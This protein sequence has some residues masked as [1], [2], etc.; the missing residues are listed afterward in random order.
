[1][2][3][4]LKSAT[5]ALAVVSAAAMIFAASGADAR[6]R[7]GAIGKTMDRSAAMDRTAAPAGLAVNELLGMDVQTR[8]GEE[9][10][11][12][13][14]V[15]LSRNGNVREVVLDYEGDLVAVPIQDLRFNQDFAVYHGTRSDLDNA[16][17]FYVYGSG[18]YVYS[19]GTTGDRRAYYGADVRYG[20]GQMTDQRLGAPE[21]W[22]YVYSGPDAYPYGWSNEERS[23]GAQLFYGPQMPANEPWFDEE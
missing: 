22:D 2:Y 9:I 10:A 4:L 16:R 13:E 19:R 6:E 12:I 15:I 3:E 18:P 21:R 7:G 5:K 23:Y 11:S 17:D 20:R 8:T 1:M 14:D